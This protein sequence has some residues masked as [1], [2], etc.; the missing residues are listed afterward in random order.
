MDH[1]LEIYRHGEEVISA[2]SE[3]AGNGKAPPRGDRPLLCFLDIKMPGIGGHDVLKWIREQ[4]TL[5]LLPVIM[6]SSSDHPEDIR[7]AAQPG[8]PL[9]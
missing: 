7:Q 3:V 5:D 1:P 8:E 9:L 4:P 6:L 2:L